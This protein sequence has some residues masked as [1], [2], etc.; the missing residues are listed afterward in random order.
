[1]LSEFQKLLVLKFQPR[2]LMDKADP[3]P[4]RLIGC[5]VFSEPGMSRSFRNLRLAQ[6]N[7][8]NTDPCSA[9]GKKIL[10]DVGGNFCGNEEIA[11]VFTHANVSDGFP[12]DSGT[13]Q[14]PQ[15]IPVA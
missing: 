12:S 8:G 14:R 9:G 6:G 2:I 1:M 10:Q 7:S 3:F 15:K 13:H 5:T 4:V 11:A